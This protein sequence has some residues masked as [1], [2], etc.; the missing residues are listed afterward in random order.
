MVKL[1]VDI[2]RG[3]SIIEVSHIRFP[4]Y[5]GSNFWGCVLKICGPCGDT[6]FENEFANRRWFQLHK[7]LPF[8]A[9]LL[10]VIRALAHSFWTAKK[11]TAPRWVNITVLFVHSNN[12]SSSSNDIAHVHKINKYCTMWHVS[13]QWRTRVGGFRVFKPPPPKFRRPF[14][15]S[16]QTQPDCEN[17]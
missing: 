4:L 14:K 15:K 8:P 13:G 5:K 1:C 9:T 12:N 6:S 17:C 16:C 3:V 7:H 11:V 10:P 2:H